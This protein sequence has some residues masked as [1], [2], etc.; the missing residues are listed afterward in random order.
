MRLGLRGKILLLVA[1]G[2]LPVGAA[3]FAILNSLLQ[4]IRLDLTR[5]AAVSY[6][7]LHRERAIASIQ[8]DLI[9]AR[10]MADAAVLREWVGQARELPPPRAVIEQ[11][12]SYI[13][14]FTEHS[15]FVASQARA[16]FYD[17][18][19]KALEAA[20]GQP[21]KVAYTLSRE[22]TEDEWFSG[23]LA[24]PSPTTSMSTTTPNCA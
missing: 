10:K 3:M 12:R 21:L 14:L 24:R 6:V 7:E 20:A 11:L 9:L 4:D 8:G 15:V 19:N 23:P 22:R 1:A 2:I 18:N 17:I 5:D 13:D 16:S